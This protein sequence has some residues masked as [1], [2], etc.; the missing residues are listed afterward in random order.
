MAD[1]DLFSVIKVVL[2]SLLLSFVLISFNS[3]RRVAFRHDRS[4]YDQA[5]I[6]VKAKKN[7]LVL[8]DATA[9]SLLLFEY[10]TGRCAVV[11]VVV[12]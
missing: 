10:R 9:A 12:L 3:F 7:P 1:V 5:Q 8:R 11:D 2:L 6:E 4:L